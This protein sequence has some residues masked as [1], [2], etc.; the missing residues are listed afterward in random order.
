MPN[1]YM[2]IFLLTRRMQV[3][4]PMRY[5]LPARG[6]AMKD[7]CHQ[8]LGKTRSNQH[9]HTLLMGMCVCAAVL[10]NCLGT[11]TKAKHIF[12]LDPA[13]ILLGIYSKQYIHISP[14]I[15]SVR[16]FVA[17]LFTIG[18]YWKQP[19]SLPAA[20]WTNEL[21]KIHTIE[22]YTAKRMNAP[23]YERCQASHNYRAK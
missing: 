16:M 3:K 13:I 11:S 21:W 7:R 14:Q 23:D 19:K 22:Q 18:L 17:A 15:F 20:E 12:I 8:T 4:T 9:T 6:A 10:E 2:L 5:Y 1:T